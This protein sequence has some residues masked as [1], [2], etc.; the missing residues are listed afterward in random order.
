MSPAPIEGSR[1]SLARQ[2]GTAPAREPSG[3]AIAAGASAAPPPMPRQDARL[4]PLSL[5]ARR[6]PATDSPGGFM[7]F[8]SLSPAPHVLIVDDDPESIAPVQIWLQRNGARTTL[9]VTPDAAEAILGRDPVDVVL[10]DIHMP[11]NNRL[12]WVRQL[13]GMAGS[14][15][16]FILTGQPEMDTA[17]VAANLP[18][19]GYLVKPPDYNE[20]A[21]RLGICIHRWRLRHDLLGRLEELSRNSTFG[22]NEPGLA[23]QLRRL[24][25]LLQKSPHVSRHPDPSVDWPAVI[26]DTIGVLVKTKG[27]FHSKELAALRRKLSHLLTLA[28]GRT[29][30]PV[31]PS[32][33]KN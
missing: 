19:A 28:D 2:G 3:P 16:V 6:E 17:L 22:E 21:G 15:P 14:P 20:L 23:A 18:L 26:R 10:C 8:R 24:A 31:A 25:S 11:G 27:S 5:T 1:A 29:D 9:A 4:G 33:G 30:E 7:A 32:E 12:E 13:T